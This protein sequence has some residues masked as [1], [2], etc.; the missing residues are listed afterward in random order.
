MT[1]SKRT[2][3]LTLAALLITACLLIPA[4]AGA[5]AGTDSELKA[6]F[7][8]NFKSNG[9]IL[10]GYGNNFCGTL[11]LYIKKDAGDEEINAFTTSLFAFMQEKGYKQPAVNLHRAEF[12]APVEKAGM[13]SVFGMHA[14][15]QQHIRK[16]CSPLLLRGYQSSPSC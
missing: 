8:A 2:F 9:G 10:T 6:F 4:A 3:A 15:F 16:N 12:S 5:V 7:D 13:N 14:G 1:P 11:N